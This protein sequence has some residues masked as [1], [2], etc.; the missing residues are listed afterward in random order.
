L[1][2][3]TSVQLIPFLMASSFQYPSSVL[4]LAGD[5]VRDLGIYKVQGIL[6]DGSYLENV[7]C[8]LFYREM[9]T[10]PR[11][12]EWKD[13]KMA[14]PSLPLPG[15][16]MFPLSFLVIISKSSSS[17]LARTNPAPCNSYRTIL[18]T[19]S[20]QPLPRRKP[21]PNSRPLTLPIHNNP[22]I[23][24]TPVAEPPKIQLQAVDASFPTLVVVNPTPR[25]FTTSDSSCNT[26]LRRW[27]YH[28]QSSRIQR[29]RALPEPGEL[30]LA[31]AD[32]LQLETRPYEEDEQRYRFWEEN[33]QKELDPYHK[34]KQDRSAHDDQRKT[35]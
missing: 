18:D 34:P 8:R 14:Q 3:A 4:S 22:S 25:P 16:S 11:V 15:Q 29:L 20:P 12:A 31:H 6:H 19:L 23:L 21:T 2:S 26:Y 27:R 7:P 28:S 13:D 17:T 33:Y 35:R 30:P 5:T 10:T 1:F 9:V 32:D 24:L